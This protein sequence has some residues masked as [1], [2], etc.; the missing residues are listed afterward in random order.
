[1]HWFH[2]KGTLFGVRNNLVKPSQ[3]R[4]ILVDFCLE[5]SLFSYYSRESVVFP[6]LLHL[7]CKIK[8]YGEMNLSFLEVGLINQ[9]PNGG[10]TGK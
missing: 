8:N 1:M 5:E 4:G 9:V 2:S 6:C 7:L 3:S 10:C